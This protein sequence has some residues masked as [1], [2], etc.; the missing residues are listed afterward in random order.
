MTFQVSL[1]L[2]LLEQLLLLDFQSSEGHFIWFF[3]VVEWNL[4]VIFALDVYQMIFDHPLVLLLYLL[5]KNLQALG[6]HE[7]DESDEELKQ[8]DV[9]GDFVRYLKSALTS[10][11]EE[12][13][14][15]P[16]QPRYR[17]LHLRVCLAE[18]IWN[19]SLYLAFSS[20]S[21]C[22]DPK[23]PSTQAFFSID[24]TLFILLAL[25]LILEVDL[26]W[27]CCILASLLTSFCRLPAKFS[28]TGKPYVWN[29]SSSRN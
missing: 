13:T 27:F 19:L 25:S 5:Q 3:D 9:L 29:L 18:N 4:F 6:F 28:A 8:I 20:W 21:C 22:P 23:A 7:Q 17:L 14:R 15:V 12:I 24:P 10:F 26:S 2:Q 11:S 1:P 16:P